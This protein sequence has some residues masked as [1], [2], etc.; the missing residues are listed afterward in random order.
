MKQISNNTEEN[1]RRLLPIVLLAA[2]GDKS[3]KVQNAVRILNKISKQLNKQRK[4][5]CNNITGKT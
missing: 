5:G 2:S 4:Y 3:I 1:L